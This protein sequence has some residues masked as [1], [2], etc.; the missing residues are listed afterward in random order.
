MSI[1]N[2]VQI[3]ESNPQRIARNI[4]HRLNGLLRRIAHQTQRTLDRKNENQEHLGRF[5]QMHP[6]FI[7][8][9]THEI[10]R[11][12]VFTLVIIA[13]YVS[14]LLMINQVAE[15]LTGMAFSGDK[16]AINIGRF[17]V[18]AVIILIEIG[19]SE[20]IVYARK[21]ANQYVNRAPELPWILVG[22]VFLLIMPSILIATHL[23]NTQGFNA[24]VKEIFNWQAIGLVALALVSHSIVIFGGRPMHEAKAFGIFKAKQV[25][26]R[27]RLWFLNRK[28]S[29]QCTKLI[30]TFSNYAELLT[31]YNG[32]FSPQIQAGP[33]DRMTREVVN[34]LMGYEAIAMPSGLG[35]DSS[36]PPSTPLNSPVITGS[37]YGDGSDPSQNRSE[38]AETPG[39]EEGYLRT[40]LS[41]YQRE[42]DSEVKP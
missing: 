41:R 13:A 18:P 11:F 7:P 42:A 24:E 29:R 17:I 38:Q 25:L 31:D 14:D 8:V 6:E 36:A 26:L 21:Y 37:V 27:T 15:Y 32:R 35:N 20:L 39:I 12:F 16:S 40:I 30:G 5:E 34:Q 23:A 22:I 4:I 2:N 9:T 3:V 19:I 33:F 1:N 28:Y 10:V